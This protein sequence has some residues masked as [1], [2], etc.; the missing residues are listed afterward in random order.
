VHGL[1][2]LQVQGSTIRRYK[3]VSPE[4][5]INPVFM[6]FNWNQMSPTHKK[7]QRHRR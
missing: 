3:A 5:A 4:E 1:H 7:Q 2:I 6:V